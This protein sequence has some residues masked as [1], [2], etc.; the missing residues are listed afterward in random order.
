MNRSAVQALAEVLRKLGRY[1]AWLDPANATPEQLASVAEALTEARHALDRASRPAPTTAC[2]RHPG[3]PTEPGTTA[4]CLLCR[5]TR[6]R[7]AT[8][9]TDAFDPD[10]TE[11]LAA[12]AEHGQDAA[13]TRYGGLSVTRALAATH[14]TKTPKRTP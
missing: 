2:R 3:G 8:S 11:V 6:A 7:S 14:R 5:T 1:G 13:A 4:G 10:I 12:I 9:P